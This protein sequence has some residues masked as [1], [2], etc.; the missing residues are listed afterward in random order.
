MRPLIHR[1]GIGSRW[2]SL[3]Y[4]LHGDHLESGARYEEVETGHVQDDPSLVVSLL[5]D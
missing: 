4:L 1:R 2:E 3:S 5:G